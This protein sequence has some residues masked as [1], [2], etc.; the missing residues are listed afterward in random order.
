MS[1]AI[2]KKLGELEMH[3]GELDDNKDYIHLKNVAVILSKK[4][5]VPQGSAKSSRYAS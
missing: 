4:S 3:E 2:S 1:C 5:I